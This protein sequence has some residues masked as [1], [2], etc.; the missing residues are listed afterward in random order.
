MTKILRRMSQRATTLL[1]QVFWLS[2]LRLT[3]F[4]LARVTLI[5]LIGHHQSLNTDRIRR[6]GSVFVPWVESDRLRRV[7]QVRGDS[8]RRPSRGVPDCRRLARLVLPPFFLVNTSLHSQSLFTHRCGNYDY[9]S[10]NSRR[11]STDQCE[12]PRRT[13]RSIKCSFCFPFAKF[14]NKLDQFPIAFARY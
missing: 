10:L 4:R 2:S 7:G 1:R 8:R 9:C 5:Q 6:A 12:F 13:S 3:P 14:P 11:G